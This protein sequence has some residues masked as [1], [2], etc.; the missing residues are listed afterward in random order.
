MNTHTK[1][2]P[3]KGETRWIDNPTR[4]TNYLNV[5]KLQAPVR[6]LC[7]NCAARTDHRVGH[8]LHANTDR[9]N[10]VL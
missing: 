1:K 3:Q 5:S 7:V 6:E 10:Y 8:R 2:A 9:G 4:R